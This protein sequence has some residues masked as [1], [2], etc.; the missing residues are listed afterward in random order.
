MLRRDLE[1]AGVPYQDEQGRFLDFHSLRHTFGK[2]LA[3]AGV[4]PKLA[5]ELMRHSEINLTMNIC[6]HVDM[7]DMAAA[8]ER[9]PTSSSPKQHRATGTDSM[10]AALVA[11]KTGDR[12]NYQELSDGTDDQSDRLSPHRDGERKSIAGKE[13]TSTNSAHKKEPPMRLEL[14][15]YAL[16]KRR[17]AN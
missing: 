12:G 10:V 8:T 15:T 17:S 2:N 4:S 11:V 7:P 13:F 14:M 3:K 6:T 5:Q 16:R 1:A 9:L